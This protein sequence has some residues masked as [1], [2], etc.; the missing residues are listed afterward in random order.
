MRLISLLSMFGTLAVAQQL[1]L[2]SIAVEGSRFPQALI[3]KWAGLMTGQL[4]DEPAI[5]D[6]CRKLQETGLFKAAEYRYSFPAEKTG[7]ALVLNLRD[8]PETLAAEAD[9][10]GVADAILWEWLGPLAAAGHR[11]PGNEAALSIYARAM[12][13]ALAAHGIKQELTTRMGGKL[14]SAASLKVY[15][16]PKNLPRIASIHFEGARRISNAALEQAIARLALESPFTRNQFQLL[17]DQNI[18][19][20][21]EEH[22]MLKT[23]FTI[24][25]QPLADGRVDVTTVI[26]EGVVYTL[27]RVDVRGGGDA[28]GFP[29]G[30]TANWNEVLAS[31]AAMEMPLRREGYLSVRS[32]PERILN[33]AAGT[34][35]LSITVEKGPQFHFGAVS[36][37]GLDAKLEQV[38]RQ[39]WTLAPGQPMD[40]GYADEFIKALF[41]HPEFPRGK[42]ASVQMKRA[43][44]ANVMDVTIT[45]R[46]VTQ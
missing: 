31:I 2:T 11:V 39:V 9:I 20:I 29:T 3:L 33:D 45:F 24:R 12:E 42:A 7:Y 35:D 30:R 17:I 1:P 5:A 21:Y 10:P 23:S 32:R 34:L 26:D 36:F 37:A 6:A 8:E 14:G 16:Q 40:A 19:R 15:F 18:R 22:G 43:A 44:G 27:A 38:A 41:A 13:Q 28:T 4:A 25:T 46:N